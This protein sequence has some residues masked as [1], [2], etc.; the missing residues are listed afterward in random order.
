MD[1]QQKLA[2][3]KVWSVI[4]SLA[5][6]TVIIT[7]VMVIYNMADVFFIGKTGDVNMINAISVCMPI[8]PI[9]QAFGTL[10][11]AGGCT[12]ISVALGQKDVEKSKK[13][14]SFCFYFCVVVG[15]LMALILN[16]FTDP[17]ISMLGAA[18]SYRSYAVLYLRFLAIGCPVMMF[19]NGF[20][21]I[22]RADGSMKE[23]MIA[24]LSGTIT[25]IILDPIFILVFNMGVVGAAVA[26]VLGNLLSS[27]ILARLLKGKS[28]YISVN[29]KDVSLSF[30]TA[31][32]PMLLG[33]PIASGTLLM[34][35]S[36]MVINNL[37]LAVSPDAQGA[38]GISRSIMLLST[39][40][41][42]GI[43]MGVQPA[44]S[45]NYGRGNI[46]R[47]K[48]FIK[49][50]TIVCMTFGL[51]I[52][53]ICIGGRDFLLKAFIDDPSIIG[54]GRQILIGCFITAPI[55]AVYQSSVTFLQAT[56]RAITSTII[57]IMRQGLIL[58][59]A[60]IVL[61]ILFGF[62]GLIFCFAVVDVVGAIT[63]I[64]ALSRHLS[65]KSKACNKVKE[66]SSAS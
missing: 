3:G 34:S 28:N 37:L 1:K 13:I 38:F 19:S 9:I 20:V 14:S 39:T 64:I 63:G 16:I 30:D 66:L 41:Q 61:N 62:N 27:V 22:M 24:N 40:T 55:Y 10:I 43:C 59:P 35:V 4:A 32:H 51:L 45:F 11:G 36:Y 48:E 15:I 49:K 25:N 46:G 60:M 23:P 26:T 42:L 6:P 33:L 65:M 29:P 58:I 12:A 47:V 7:L 54:Y 21:N 56:D 50:T 31:I 2:E 17:I 52:A 44:V 5:I 8:F 18:Q 53:L 57:T